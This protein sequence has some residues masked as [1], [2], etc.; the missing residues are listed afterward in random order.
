MLKGVN[1]AYDAS[2]LG[3]PTGLYGS[4]AQAHFEVAIGLD[5]ERRGLLLYDPSLVV[6][7]SPADRLDADQRQLPSR[8]SI[9][10][11]A[12]NAVLAC[13]V[14]STTFACGR[15]IA[16]LMLGDASV[17]GIG[18]VLIGIANSDIRRRFLPSIVGT[19]RGLLRVLSGR[20]VTFLRR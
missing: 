19:L 12:S 4:G 9:A 17:P 13:G 5:L 18:R 16:S 3:I 7:H 10:D 14:R 11:V 20:P 8:R 6:R 15:A 2:V 1:C